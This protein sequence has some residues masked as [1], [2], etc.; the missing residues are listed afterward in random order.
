MAKGKPR[1]AGAGGGVILEKHQ[2]SRNRQKPEV[3]KPEFSQAAD[4]FRDAEP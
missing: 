4:I 1:T 2:H 3:Q